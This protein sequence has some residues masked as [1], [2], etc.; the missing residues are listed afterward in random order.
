[1]T[2][3]THRAPPHSATILVGMAIWVF[4]KNRDLLS[5]ERPRYNTPGLSARLYGRF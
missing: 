4:P 3:M 2:S 5:H 1:M